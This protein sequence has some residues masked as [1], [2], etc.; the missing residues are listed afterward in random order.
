MKIYWRLKEVPEFARLAPK[1]RRRVHELC[2]RQYFL[3]ARWGL[4]AYIVFLGSG[5]LVGVLTNDATARLSGSA[6]LWLTGG[7]MTAGMMLGRY[8]FIRM[9]IPILR[10]F[11]GRFIEGNRERNG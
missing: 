1:E 10:P 11:Y 2:L 3:N 6:S 8:I 4:L 7:A 9:A 5:V